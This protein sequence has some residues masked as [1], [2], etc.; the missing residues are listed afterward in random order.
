MH[1]LIRPYV[2]LR[3][4]Y[5]KDKQGTLDHAEF[6]KLIRVGLKVNEYDFS[7]GLARSNN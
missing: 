1:A 2:H 4:R 3:V 7:E 5:D 6:R